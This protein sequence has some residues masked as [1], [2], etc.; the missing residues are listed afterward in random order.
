[1]WR[2]FIIVPTS[3][4]NGL[5]EWRQ[6]RAV[7]RVCL[8]GTPIIW[9][10][11]AYS[12]TSAKERL[13][14]GRLTHEDDISVSNSSIPVLPLGDP[15]LAPI[16]LVGDGRGAVPPTFAA[17]PPFPP[18]PPCFFPNVPGGDSMP[19]MPRMSAIIPLASLRTVTISWSWMEGRPPS[20]F[21]GPLDPPLTMS[22]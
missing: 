19:P 6:S 20:S 9:D 16:A 8:L 10:Q 1:M 22:R 4:T 14:E 12:T 11:D 3:F 15:S 2:M 13:L 21:P 7:V 17:L 5:Q 18:A